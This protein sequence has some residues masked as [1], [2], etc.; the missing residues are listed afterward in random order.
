MVNTKAVIIVLGYP[1]NDDGDPSPIL[2]SR[3]DKAIEIYRSGQA[4]KI[5]VT[6]AAVYNQFVEAEVMNVYCIKNGISPEDIFMEPQAR[7]TYDNA[8]RVRKIMYDNGF[9]KA[10]VVTS[11]FHKMRAQR[12]FSKHIYNAT[13]VAAPFPD[14]FPI[15]KRLFFQVKEIIILILFSL[16]LLKNRYAAR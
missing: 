10:I 13:V 9:N 2:R 12:F 4:G 15:A 7:N 11:G 8:R 3:L 14:R 6:G 16:G 5:I 1:A